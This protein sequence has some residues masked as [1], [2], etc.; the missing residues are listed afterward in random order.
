MRQILFALFHS[1][2][3]LFSPAWQIESDG[4]CIADPD[5]KPRCSP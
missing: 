2:H 4:G 5:G 1:L 3:T